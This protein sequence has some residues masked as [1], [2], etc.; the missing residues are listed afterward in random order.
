MRGG[1]WAAVVAVTLGAAPSSCATAPAT[2]NFNPVY[3]F[4][5]P[6]SAL[7]TAVIDVAADRNWPIHLIL[8]TSVRQPRGDAGLL[9]RSGDQRD[10]GAPSVPITL[11]DCVEKV[12]LVEGMVVSDVFP[13]RFSPRSRL[14]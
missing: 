7:G 5:V 10:D 8:H 9:W 6:R 4:A 2:Y 11:A 1:R 14:R 13:I 3:E 12:I